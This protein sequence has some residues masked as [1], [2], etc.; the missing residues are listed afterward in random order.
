MKLLKSGGLIKITELNITE[1]VAFMKLNAEMSFINYDD[2]MLNMESINKFG[3]YKTDNGLLDYGDIVKFIKTGL[4]SIEISIGEFKRIETV[5][6]VIDKINES[7]INSCNYIDYYNDIFIISYEPFKD[8]GNNILY[9]FEDNNTFIFFDENGPN[10]K[11]DTK[12][13]TFL[14]LVS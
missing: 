6:L 10:I 4:K 3:K 13:S 9:Y 8:G 2:E 1:I 11:T 12:S 7:V 14:D 5:V